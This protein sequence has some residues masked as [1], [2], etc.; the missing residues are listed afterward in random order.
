[1]T[2]DFLLSKRSGAR[3]GKQH[4]GEEAETKEE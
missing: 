2:H 4:A 1:M 3:H